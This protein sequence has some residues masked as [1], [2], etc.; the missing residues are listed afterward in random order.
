MYL[1]PGVTYTDIEAKHILRPLSA[2]LQQA[3]AVLILLRRQAWVRYH[4]LSQ[5]ASSRDLAGVKFGPTRGRDL[6]KT[7]DDDAE[8]RLPATV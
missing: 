1:D 2:V 6:N 5:N 8:R 4:F 3:W 7:T